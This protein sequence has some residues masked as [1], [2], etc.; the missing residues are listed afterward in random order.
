M[1]DFHCHLLPALDDGAVNVDES[2]AMARSLA[3]FGYKTVFC[4][5]HCIKGYYDLTPQ[6]VREATL[7]LQADL[8]NADI[9]L[10]LRPGME[11]MLDECFSEFAEDLLPLGD[12]K[13][14][15]CEAPQQAHPGFVQEGLELIIK[16]GFVPLIA[17][18]ERTDHFYDIISQRQSSEESEEKERLEE[19]GTRDEEDLQKKPGLFG[20]IWPF[21]PRASRHAPLRPRIMPHKE[22]PEICQFQ[23]NLGSFTGYYGESVQRQAYELLKQGVYSALATDL[24]DGASSSKILERGKFE[25]NPLLEALAAWDGSVQPL[26]RVEGDGGEQGRLF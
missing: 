10:E 6:K 1:I 5:P 4:T 9:A 21:A 11:Y 3:D 16:K 20:R 22:L 8:D 14:V 17:H 13:L 15:L 25:T 2:I 12:T 24:H 7:M 26:E 23:A 19:R 18:P